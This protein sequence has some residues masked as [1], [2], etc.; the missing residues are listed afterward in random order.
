MQLTIPRREKKQ[1]LMKS[2]QETFQDRR[3]WI[4]SEEPTI[5]DIA[6]KFPRL[7]DFYGEMVFHET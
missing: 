6:E 2:L 4:T 7:F 3:D 1:S 5:F